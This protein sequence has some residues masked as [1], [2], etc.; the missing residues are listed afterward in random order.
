MNCS[1]QLT[2]GWS[3]L[4]RPRRGNMR[5]NTGGEQ[6][7]RARCSPWKASGRSA[8]LA[9]NRP[10]VRDE[11]K[12]QLPIIAQ[13][14]SCRSRA[15][16]CAARMVKPPPRP[17]PTA[18]PWRERPAE[19]AAWPAKPAARDGVAHA[20]AGGFGA[21]VGAIG[22]PQVSREF[23]PAH[24]P[25]HRC[26]DLSRILAVIR[27]RLHARCAQELATDP[28]QNALYFSTAMFVRNIGHH[29]TRIELCSASSRLSLRSTLR[30]TAL[31]PPARSSKVAFM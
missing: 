2:R 4:D 5:G 16:H 8:R 7:P 6:G 15:A 25:L 30:A 11:Q 23:R 10:P 19:M 1:D 29:M 20:T 27:S 22:P 3:L 31:T 26:R 21:R 24:G 12:R 9:E 18:I 28:L 17:E 14:T 13:V